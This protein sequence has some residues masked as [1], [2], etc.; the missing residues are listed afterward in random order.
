VQ[1]IKAMGPSKVGE[2][3]GKL[4]EAGAKRY[5]KSYARMPPNGSRNCSGGCN[6]RE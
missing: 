1:V 6:N 2:A 4:I 5:W 3:L